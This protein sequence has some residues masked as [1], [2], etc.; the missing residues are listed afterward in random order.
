MFAVD[1]L[2]SHGKRVHF[3]APIKD[4][5]YPPASD[6]DFR[7]LLKELGQSAASS[8]GI[9]Q[10]GGTNH[11]EITVHPRAH[12]QEADIYYSRG[13]GTARQLKELILRVVRGAESYRV[14]WY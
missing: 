10:H 6:M 9:S 2:Q 4:F 12:T 14:L 8:V 11:I 3:S 5:R 13:G 1:C 7:P